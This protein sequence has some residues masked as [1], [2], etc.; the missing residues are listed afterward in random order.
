MN[1]LVVVESMFGNTHQIGE[2]ITAG[3]SRFSSVTFDTRIDA[4][5]L[6]GS[7]A[8]R[9]HRHGYRLLAPQRASP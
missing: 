1:T 3:L 5:W 7:A 6:P 8:G 9:L 2:A 4:A